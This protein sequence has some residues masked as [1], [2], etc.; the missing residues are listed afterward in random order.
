METLTVSNWSAL[1]QKGL[2]K[3]EEGV[4]CVITGAQLVDAGLVPALM[5]VGSKL[6]CEL[7]DVGGKRRINRVISAV[8]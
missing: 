4:A 6:H 2:A 1:D 3:D 7:A 8:L 5:R